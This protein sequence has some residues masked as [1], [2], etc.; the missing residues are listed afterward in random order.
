MPE[1]DPILLARIQFAFTISF[2]IVFPAFTIGLASYLAVLEGCWLRTGNENYRDLYKFW[3][4]IFAVAFGMG[5]VSGVVMAYQFGTNWSIFSDRVANVIGPLL[6]FEVLTA[7]FLE[8]SFLG[9][10]LFGWNRVSPRMHF[11]STCVVAVG[12]L[13]SAFWILAANSWMQT[14]Q[15][16]TIAAD[17]RLFPTNWL[18]IIFNPSFPYRFVHMIMAAYLTTALVVGGVA[19]FYILSKRYLPQ[20]R[21]M[22]GMATLMA[23]LV[24]P[25]Q[26]ASGDLHGINTL[27]HQPAKVA[28]IEGIWNTEKGAG[29]RLVAWPNEETESNKYEVV[30]PHLASWILTHSADGEV[31]GL[32]SWPK[33]ERPPVAFVF[34]AFRVMVGLGVLMLLIGL[35]S[36]VQYF[37]G[38]LFQSRRLHIWWMLMTP[39]GFLALLSGWMVTEIGRQ[40][41]TAY[42]II[43]TVHSV[44]PAIVGPQVL[45]SLLAFVVIYTLVFGA[46]IY[47]IIKLIR[48]GIP[49]KDEKE[50]FYE[51]SIEAT[52]LG[53]NTKGDGSHV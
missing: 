40:P 41:Y 16:F 12:T 39:A 47:Y 3:I 45:A 32:K 33:D 23:A 19:A 20:A 28:A 31:K 52:M 25:L 7:F 35:T 17:G 8:A 51:H 15:G 26:V 22:L 1:L 49:A 30:I 53:A 50:Q 36:A 18:E 29:L 14:P 46:G 2:H 10:M 24:T 4:K 13:I 42:G 37:R 6:G 43:K 48:K 38:N 11:F 21:I 27:E 5:V 34:W 9:I 44:S